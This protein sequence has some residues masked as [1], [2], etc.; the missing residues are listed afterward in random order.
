MTRNYVITDNETGF[1]TGKYKPEEQF[2]AILI[3]VQVKTDYE[4]ELIIEDLLKQGY[5]NLSIIA[6]YN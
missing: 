2:E 6:V 1:Y 3:A 5:E 4:A